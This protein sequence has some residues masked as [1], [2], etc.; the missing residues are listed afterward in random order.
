MSLYN[1]F[2]DYAV[3][4]GFCKREDCVKYEIRDEIPVNDTKKVEFKHKKNI[5]TDEQL[6]ALRVHIADTLDRNIEFCSHEN[7]LEVAIRFCM[8]TYDEVIKSVDTNVLEC[9]YTFEEMLNNLWDSGMLFEGRLHKGAK[10]LKETPGFEDFKKD[11]EEIIKTL[12]NGKRIENQIYIVNCCNFIRNFRCNFTFD[13]Y[14]SVMNSKKS[15]RDVLRDAMNR[16]TDG[17]HMKCFNTIRKYYFPVLSTEEGYNSGKW[18]HLEFLDSVD[19]RYLLPSSV[20]KWLSVVG[21]YSYSQLYSVVCSFYNWRDFCRFICCVFTKIS[22][23]DLK[24]IEILLKRNNTEECS[25]AYP[26]NTE[27]KFISMESLLAFY[28]IMGMENYGQLCKYVSSAG[29]SS[30]AISYTSVVEGAKA[31]DLKNVCYICNRFDWLSEIK[32]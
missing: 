13:G 6:S 20:V 21:I 28:E 25:M 7:Y 1:D 11:L 30:V 26:D 8:K 29:Y 5:L 32:G 23:E 18:E 3:R 19:L 15:F 14:Y 22:E 31:D 27:L 12:S 24:S 16:S 2:V 10:N 4:L 17:D 9:M